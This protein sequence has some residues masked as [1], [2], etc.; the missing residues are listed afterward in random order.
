MKRV[1]VIFFSFILFPGIV[2]QPLK[3]EQCYEAA[4]NNYPLINNMS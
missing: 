3:L 2:G 4:K 1:F